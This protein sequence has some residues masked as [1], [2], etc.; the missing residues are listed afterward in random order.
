MAIYP[1]SKSSKAKKSCS[2]A[3]TPSTTKGRKKKC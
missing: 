3:K 2:T 1:Y